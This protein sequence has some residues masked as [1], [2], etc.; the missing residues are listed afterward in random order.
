M[1][2]NLIIILIKLRQEKAQGYVL[3]GKHPHTRCILEHE[4]ELPN[5]IRDSYISKE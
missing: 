5:K 1:F 3:L 2:I 4:Y